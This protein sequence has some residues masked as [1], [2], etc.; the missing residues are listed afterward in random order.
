MHLR[1][2]IPALNE[3]ATIA[4]VIRRAIEAGEGIVADHL[5]GRLSILMVDDG[6]MDGTSEL[7]SQAAAGGP[8]TILRHEH[9]C[10]LGVCFREGFVHA[11]ETDVD[12]LVHLDGDGQFDPFDMGRLV[13]PVMLERVDLALG[14][15]RAGLRPEPETPVIDRLG[16]AALAAGLSALCGQRFHDVSCGYRA[17]SRRAMGSLVMDGDYTYTHE[18]ILRSCRAGLRV[19]EIAVPVR[20]RRPFGT[21]RLVRGRVRYGLEAAKIICRV[22]RQG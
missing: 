20:G 19:R 5:E 22:A 13:E 6:S 15:R 17:F 14:S 4:W 18:S 11:R 12:V 9:P 1:V 16:N 2:Q 3:A 10:G 8:L 7:A 21:S